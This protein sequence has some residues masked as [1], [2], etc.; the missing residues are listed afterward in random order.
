MRSAE[1]ERYVADELSWDP[2]VDSESIAV[3]VEDGVVTLRGT[4]GSFRQKIEA[5]RAAGRIR[6]VVLVE[7][8]LEV[9]ILDGSRRADADLRGDVLRALLL[10]SHLPTSVEAA[11]QDG[12]VTLTGEVDWQYQ[13]NEAVFVAGNVPGVT[14]VDDQIRLS[15]PPSSDTGTEQAIRRAF[16]RDAR[17]AADDLIVVTSNGIATL[18]GTVHSLAERDAAVA[19]AWTAPGVIAVED[20]LT[21]TN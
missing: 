4:V 19:A 21:V 3:S 9:T 14:G 10:D 7:N 2:K 13:R 20:R 12:H 6:G 17:L 1:L 5:E 11:V 8:D 18:M 16:A 15:R